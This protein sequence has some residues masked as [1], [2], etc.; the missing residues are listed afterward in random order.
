MFI[1][2]AISLNRTLGTVRAYIQGP[3]VPR[4]T[5]PETPDEI[6]EKN[7]LRETIN[8]LPMLPRGEY[9]SEQGWLHNRK[10][11]RANILQ[12]D[13]RFFLT[14]PVIQREMV[15]RSNSK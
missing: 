2:G 14:W 10:E 5:D 8:E 1:E 7:K 11:L 3:R 15:A 12:R 6:E 4:R 9:R 13:P